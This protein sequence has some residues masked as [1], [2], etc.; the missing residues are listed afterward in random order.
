L[1][2]GGDNPPAALG[3]E[4][5]AFLEPESD[6]PLIDIPVEPYL[7][8]ETVIQEGLVHRAAFQAQIEKTQQVLEEHQPDKV[9]V[10]GGDC[11]VD[12]VPFAYLNEKYEGE[13]AILWIDAHPDIKNPSEYHL[14]INGP[15][16]SKLLR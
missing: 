10:F 3:A 5:L 1:W 6:S 7:G 8:Q 9:V 16:K 14:A 2:Q 11:Q 4:L 15:I 12:H 13:L